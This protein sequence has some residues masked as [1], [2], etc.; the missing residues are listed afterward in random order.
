MEAGS[1]ETETK[2]L[3]FLH[4]PIINLSYVRAGTI[5][6]ITDYLAGSCGDVR[7]VHACRN[8]CT[9]DLV[10]Q[11]CNR[12]GCEVCNLAVAKKKAKKVAERYL[13]VV[14]VMRDQGIEPGDPKH[15]SWSLDPRKVTCKSLEE[16]DGIKKLTKQLLSVLRS[17]AKDG[18]YGGTLIFHGERKKHLDD[19]TDCTFPVHWEKGKKITCPCE[20]H[21]MWSP[22]YHYVGFG[23]FEPSPQLLK[24]TGW[25]YHI[26]PEEHGKDRDVEATLG[27]EL[28]H[29]GLFVDHELKSQ[30]QAIKWIGALS[31]SKAGRRIIESKLEASICEKCGEPINRYGHDPKSCDQVDWGSSRGP[32]QKKVEIIEWYLNKRKKKVK[33]DTILGGSPLGGGTGPGGKGGDGGA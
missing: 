9:L 25:L 13:G 18:W 27:Y 8:K 32:V 33:Q 6:K 31:N 21:W 16:G 28:T 5:P 29:V 1:P 4:M 17:S 26:I 20:H 11:V 10:P 12:L 24:R 3:Q 7:S 22:H 14:K 2:K 30:G 19:D 15:I 23:Y